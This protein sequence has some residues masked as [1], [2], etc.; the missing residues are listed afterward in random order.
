M[1]INLY[2]NP[3]GCIVEHIDHD[4]RDAS[5]RK[6]LFQTMANTGER[7]E[8]EREILLDSPAPRTPDMVCFVSS[9]VFFIDI[10]L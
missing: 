7:T 3:I 8:F 4:A 1:L 9:F 6:K 10:Y 5:L 2:R